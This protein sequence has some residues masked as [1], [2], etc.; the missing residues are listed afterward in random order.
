MLGETAVNYARNIQ[1]QCKKK[2]VRRSL[3]EA[4]YHIRLDQ[5]KQ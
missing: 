4:Q 2:L 3:D 1:R 5:D